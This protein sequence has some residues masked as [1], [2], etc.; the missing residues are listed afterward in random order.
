MPAF[1][2]T[3][4][5]TEAQKLLPYDSQDTLLEVEVLCSFPYV[6]EMVNIM[7]VIPS[8]SVMTDKLAEDFMQGHSMNQDSSLNVN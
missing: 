6:T 4:G 8:L 2:F 7:D 1:A 5:N 3:N